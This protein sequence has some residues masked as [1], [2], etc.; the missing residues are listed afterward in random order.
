MKYLLDIITMRQRASETLMSA[1]IGSD[2]ARPMGYV[3][4][5]ERPGA[6]ERNSSVFG[7]LRILCNFDG[8]M[9]DMTLPNKITKH[10]YQTAFFRFLKLAYWPRRPFFVPDQK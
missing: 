7:S 9:F 8:A 1:T 6:L 3:S 5:S 4:I 2:G 10:W